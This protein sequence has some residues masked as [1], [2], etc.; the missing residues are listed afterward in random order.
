MFNESDN[1]LKSRRK[2]LKKILNEQPKC[3]L[4]IKSTGN[5][6]HLKNLKFDKTNPKMSKLP[7]AKL[8]LVSLKDAK[9]KKANLSSPEIQLNK[10]EF[11]KTDPYRRSD[12]KS[13]KEN[14]FVDL[15]AVKPDT[16]EAAINDLIEKVKSNV[17][18][19]QVKKLCGHHHFIE[20]IDKIDFQNGDIVTH[21]GEVAFKLDFKIS[22]NL[23]LMIDRDGKLINVFRS[24]AG[25]IDQ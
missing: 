20:K 15:D 9:F 18:L 6:A 25:L 7:F 24:V 19:D 21:D 10:N 22:Y 3:V 16:I 17:Q 1:F 23:S 12:I 11:N 8:H 13:S 5:F 4:P 14:L 2:I